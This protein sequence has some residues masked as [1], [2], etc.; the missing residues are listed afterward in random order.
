MVFEYIYFCF[1]YFEEN[2][3]ELVG[4]SGYYRLKE[5]VVFIIF[6]SFFKLCRIVKIKGYSY[7]FGFFEVSWFR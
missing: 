3:F 2:C 1:K 7:L 6:E 4:I 5:G